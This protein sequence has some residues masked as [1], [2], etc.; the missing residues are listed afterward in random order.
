MSS[1]IVL[2][3]LIAPP[4]KGIMPGVFEW[5]TSPYLASS[6]DTIHLMFSKIYH[7]AWILLGFLLML[8]AGFHLLGALSNW[9]TPADQLLLKGA[10]VVLLL[11]GYQY[12]FGAIMRTGYALAQQIQETPFIV[13]Q[14]RMTDDK[15][16][17]GQPDSTWAGWAFTL[18][19]V[20]TGELGLVWI[21]IGLS[22]ILYFLICFFM[23]S[24]WLVLATVLYITGPLVMVMAIVPGGGKLAARWFGALLQ[25]SLW[26]V[27]FAICYWFM[28]AG[29]TKLF[30]G[31]GLLT[32]SVDWRT[33]GHAS[34]LEGAAFALLFGLMYLSTPY[35]VQSVF[36]LGSFE[37]GAMRGMQWGAR[38]VS[39]RY[40]SGRQVLH[41]LSRSSHTTRRA[42]PAST[43]KAEATVT[44]TGEP[45]STAA[46]TV[47]RTAARVGKEAAKRAVEI[48]KTV[49][50]HAAASIDIPAG[51]M[52]QELERSA[53]AERSEAEKGPRVASAGSGRSV[54]IGNDRRQHRDNGVGR[55]IGVGKNQV[56]GQAGS[57][58]NSTSRNDPAKVVK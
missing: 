35:V 42:P 32:D 45:V 21:I 49:E 6:R 27:W 48:V 3:A 18:L 12:S 5:M 13:D 11:V 29:A 25:L 39:K 26:Q 53:G 56:H 51:G 10:M 15:L 43:G 41:S 9:H 54:G 47:V 4:D 52:D 28:D 7:G 8:S 50:Q 24:L 22:I 23:T 40:H 57:D 30:Q 55:S 16:K 20:I 34:T 58:G 36:P 14:L 2:L 46:L 44:P 17:Q 33:M 31:E 38:L 19:K 37:G 1:A